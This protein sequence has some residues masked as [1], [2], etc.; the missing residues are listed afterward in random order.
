MSTL[1]SP[2][3]K[4][5]TSTRIASVDTLRGLVITLM[6]FVNDLGET[7]QAPILLKHVKIDA[8]SMRLPD[9]VFP[10][11][12][13]IAGMSVPLALGRALA[14]G[15]TRWHLLLKVLLRVGTLLTMGVIMVNME[16]YEPWV[17]GLWGTLAYVAMFLAFAVVPPGSGRS[18]SFRLSGK[19]LGAAA[20]VAL[21]L[22]Y[23]TSDGKGLVLGPLWDPTDTTWLRHSW[24][25]ILGLIAWAYLVASL[26][27]LVFGRRREWLVGA[28][29]W[30]VLLFVAAKS[31][32]P[33]QLASR[34]WLAWATPAIAALEA[35][36]GWV[37]GHVG[38]GGE[39][40]SL[41]SISVAGCCLGS[42][43]SEASDVREPAHRLRWALMFSLGLFLLG[44]V[45]DAPYGINKIRATPAWCMYCSAITTAAWSLLYWLM[46]VRGHR[47]WSRLFQPAGANPLLAYLLHPFLY[48]L[49]GLAGER[50]VDTLFFHH[51]LSPV[52]TVI[53]SLV[54]AFA[55]VQATGWI[56]KA[57]YRLKA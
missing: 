47:S 53:G 37:N 9:L 25:G 22:A 2:Q 18:R 8:D 44:L 51:S 52:A 10:A 36:F 55:V 23:R 4:L 34:T 27:Y 56:A 7:P 3:E 39:L 30:F 28:A 35:G 11:F 43:L 49:V 29:G 19:V 46:D 45:L 6:I 1:E 41:A 48:L 32:L 20:L 24:W 54:L 17:R 40:G 26:V 14:S 38:I 31:D 33:A 42:I 12:L 21:A 16:Q 5:G 50:A 57:G 15:Q 13:F